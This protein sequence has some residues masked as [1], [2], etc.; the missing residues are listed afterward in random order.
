V[1][2]G[3]DASGMESSG[4]D[5]LLFFIFIENSLKPI[6][7]RQMEKHIHAGYGNNV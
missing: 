3:G 5:G 6:I 1:D 4:A 7:T 2:A